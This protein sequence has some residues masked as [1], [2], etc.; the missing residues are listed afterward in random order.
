MW[1]ATS[2]FRKG[3]VDREGP[4][5]A[6]AHGEQRPI[7]G[8]GALRHGLDNKY[9]YLRIIDIPAEV[10]AHEPWFNPTLTQVNDSVVRLGILGGS[11]ADPRARPQVARRECFFYLPLKDDRQG[12]SPLNSRTLDTLSISCAILPAIRSGAGDR[13]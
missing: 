13:L 3:S 9:G 7:V 8:S 6:L 4:C 12:A 1:P 11:T 5:Q 2:S 10:A